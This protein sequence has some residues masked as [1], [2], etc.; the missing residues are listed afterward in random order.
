MTNLIIQW[1]R[2]HTLSDGFNDPHITE[3]TDLMASGLLDSF[4]FIDLLLFV[5]S[6][7]GL[8]VDLTDVDPSEF[9]VVKGLCNI[10]L[11]SCHNGRE[12]SIEVVRDGNLQQLRG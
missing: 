1:V 4:G 9:T 2:E 6:Q 5:E 3:D 7:T 8:K 11:G 12:Q 10:A